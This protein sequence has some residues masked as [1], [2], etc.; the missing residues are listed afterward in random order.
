MTGVSFSSCALGLLVLAVDLLLPRRSTR[1]T[2]TIL[3]A[4]G[5]LLAAV[6]AVLHWRQADGGVPALIQQIQLDGMLAPLGKLL[7]HPAFAAWRLFGIDRFADAFKVIFS[8]AAF[9]VLLL[10]VRY[11]VEKYRGEF[12]GLLLFATVGLDGDGE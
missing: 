11:P 4:C 2:L 9:L 6:F 12:A 8:L 3:A 10:S 7:Q 5:C 1:R